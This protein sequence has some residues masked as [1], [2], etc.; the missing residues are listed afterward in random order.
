MFKNENQ[1]FKNSNSQEEIIDSLNKQ[2]DFDPSSLKHY[3]S[4]KTL[5]GRK[6]KNPLP[7]L[8]KCEIC[9]EYNEYSSDSLISCSI[10]KCNFHKNCY[11]QLINK[12]NIKEFK[13]E[14]CYNSLRDNIPIDSIKCFICSMSDGILSYNEKNN[15]YYHLICLK[16]ISELYEDCNINDISRGKIRKWRYK[17]S[18]KY[19]NEKL[20]KE[21]AVIKCK[22]TKCKCYY[23][24][25]CAIEKGMIFSINYLKKFY[26][27]ENDNISIPFFCSSHNKKLVTQYRKNVIYNNNYNPKNINND[28]YCTDLDRKTIRKLSNNLNMEIENNYSET[29]DISTTFNNKICDFTNISPINNNFNEI[30]N[31]DNLSNFE[32][33]KILDLNFNE[34]LVSDIEDEKNEYIINFDNFSSEDKIPYTFF[35]K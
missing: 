9:L 13:C 28:N 12:L 34:L 18:C 30:D 4:K 19:C 31:D 26:S 5:R 10:C 15:I 14:R 16:F 7:N 17:N 33:N 11:P 35:S 27:I 8:T 2:S 25:P 3:I 29:M 20:S 21:K 23:H 24:I 22:N 6:I 1:T 32:Y